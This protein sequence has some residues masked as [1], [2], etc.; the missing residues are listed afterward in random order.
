MFWNEQGSVSFIECIAAQGE[1]FDIVCSK[2]CCASRDWLQAEA[3]DS[4]FE[5]PTGMIDLYSL[6][7][8]IFPGVKIGGCVA[9][10]L[11]SWVNLGNSMVKHIEG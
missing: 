11:L 10:R 9:Q 2:Q 8:E 3:N 6:R 4:R 1:V 5:Y 7:R